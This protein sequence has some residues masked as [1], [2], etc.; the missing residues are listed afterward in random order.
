MPGLSFLSKKSWHTSNL[1]NIEE[2]WVAERKKDSEVKKIAELQKQVIEERQIQELRQLQVQSGQVVKTVDTSLDWMYEGPAGYSQ[3]KSTEEYLLGK[4]YE[5]KGEEQT[6]LHKLGKSAGALWLNKV[7]SKND[8][9]TRLHEDPLLV[10][11]QKEKQTREKI[12]NNPIKLG[13][14][15]DEILAQ[16]RQEE[17]DKKEKKEAKK[18][19]KK[20]HK[21]EKKDRKRRRERSDDSDEGVGNRR[22]DERNP[23]TSR[24]EGDEKEERRSVKDRRSGPESA[25]PYSGDHRYGLLQRGEDESGQSKTNKDFLGPQPEL[26][27]KKAERDRLEREARLNAVK[28][29]NVKQMSEEEKQRRLRE[30]ETD[31]HSHEDER[32]RRVQAQIKSKAAVELSAASAQGAGKEGVAPQFLKSMRSQTYNTT[33]GSVGEKSSGISMEE[34][35]KQ[36]KFY[37]QRGGDLESDS[38]LRK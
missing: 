27:A 19:E 24:S 8:S 18:K 17:L 20:H 26:L 31:A 34:R 37:S 3:D 1:K 13:R 9:F 23:T 14:I 4:T 2:V 35:L 15:Q 36:N 5:P 38:F 25:R 29:S 33:I 22:V 21:E 30:M 7:S 6:D 10:I 12:V 16:L 28:K 11:K 32:V